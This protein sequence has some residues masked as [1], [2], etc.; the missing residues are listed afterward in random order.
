MVTQQLHEQTPL[1]DEDRKTQKTDSS[2]KK[3]VF[4]SLNYNLWC[5]S[6]KRRRRMKTAGG[7]LRF[8]C[9]AGTV[10]MQEDNSAV[11]WCAGWMTTTQL[12]P[13]R[14]EEAQQNVRHFSVVCASLLRLCWDQRLREALIRGRAVTSQQ[15]AVCRR[16]V[17]WIHKEAADW[18]DRQAEWRPADSTAT[19]VQVELCRSALRSDCFGWDRKTRSTFEGHFN[20]WLMEQNHFYQYVHCC[21]LLSHVLHKSIWKGLMII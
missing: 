7:S 9:A 18:D 12:Y 2:N 1:K 10:N 8:V 20:I 13:G 11:L 19:L 6:N 14:C 4:E 21:F 17:T 3:R 16:K 5:S 15:A